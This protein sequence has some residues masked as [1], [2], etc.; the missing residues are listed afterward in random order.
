MAKKDTSLIQITP[1]LKKNLDIISTFKS[2]VEEICN[3][4]TQIQVV[5]ETSLSVA[6]QNLSKTNSLLK[7]VEDKIKLIRKP[8]NDELAMISDVGSTLTEPLKMTVRYLKSSVEAWEKKR[9]AEEAEKQAAIDRKLAEIK[10]AEEAET[11]RIQKIRDYINNKA[12][13]VLKNCYSKCL[14]IEECDV[15]LKF[16]E[17]KYPKE[18]FFQEFTQEAMQLK[19]TYIDLIKSKK[20]QLSS[21]ANMSA[22]ELLIIKKQEEL[23]LQQANI[24]AEKKALELEKERLEAEK[25]AKLEEEAALAEKQRLADEAE[26]NKTKGVRY[27]WKVEISNTEELPYEW[28]CLNESAIKEWMKERK[29]D[30]KDG[31]VVCGVRFFKKMGVAS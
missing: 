11:S 20:E 24:E 12:I 25:R 31:Q 19:D 2:Q 9:L 6:Q 5:D 23:A 4:C 10:A 13:P 30:L 14:S 16:I 18:E 3:N 29:V 22:E 28:I 26:M 7:V 1:Q 8:Y 17:D 27:T 15:Q 21:A